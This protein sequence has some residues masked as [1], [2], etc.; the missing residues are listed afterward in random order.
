MDDRDRSAVTLGQSIAQH[1]IQRRANPVPTPAQQQGLRRTT[2]NVKALAHRTA[3]RASL[4]APL[5]SLEPRRHPAQRQDSNMKDQR[6]IEL[7]HR[8]KRYDRTKFPSTTRF[9]Y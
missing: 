3:Q 8:R 2:W 4:R 6:G 7:W 9:I 1:A 5:R